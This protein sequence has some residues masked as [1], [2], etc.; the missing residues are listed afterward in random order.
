MGVGLVFMRARR[1]R[2]FP[3]HLGIVN[4]LIPVGRREAYR[5]TK[6][7]K[8][9]TAMRTPANTQRPQRYQEEWQL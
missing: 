1:R 6:M 5:K 3:M 8:R 4:L 2:R 9:A 7:I